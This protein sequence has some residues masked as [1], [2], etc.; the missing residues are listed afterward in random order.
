MRVGHL[1]RGEHDCAGTSR[2]LLLADEEHVL[3]LDHIEKLVLIRVDVKRRV[4]RIY[5]L[6]DR[7]CATGRLCARL[8]KEDRTCEG[9]ALSGARVEVVA[10]CTSVSDSANLA[11]ATAR[12]HALRCAC[13]NGASLACA[14]VRE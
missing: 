4:E 12:V 8:D 3:A 14:S 10:V 1:P 13:R 9:Q 11:R 7:E 2:K 5:L 6:D